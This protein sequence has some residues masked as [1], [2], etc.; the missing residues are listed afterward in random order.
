MDFYI[1]QKLKAKH[2]KINGITCVCLATLEFVLIIF[3]LKYNQTYCNILICLN[4][5]VAFKLPSVPQKSYRL[6]ICEKLKKV[7]K[8]LI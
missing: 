3:A 8:L 4:S 5:F 6:I 7:S 2:I 1:K